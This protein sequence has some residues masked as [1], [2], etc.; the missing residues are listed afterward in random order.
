MTKTNKRVAKPTYRTV[1]ARDF[2]SVAPSLPSRTL[3]LRTYNKYRKGYEYTRDVWEL[4]D[5]TL[6]AGEAFIHNSREFERLFSYICEAERVKDNEQLLRLDKI[7]EEFLEKCR[8]LCSGR[9]DFLPWLRHRLTELQHAHGDFNILVAIDKVFNVLHDR[10]P[11]GE[12]MIK[13]YGRLDDAVIDEFFI[14]L[15]TI[16]DW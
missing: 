14:T 15:N 12:Q 9:C 4:R 8:N 16:R 5:K 10:G 6:E 7:S 11:V 3:I 1:V 2:K 13:G